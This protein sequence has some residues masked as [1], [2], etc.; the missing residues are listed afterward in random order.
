MSIAE[1]LTQIAKNQ[2]RVYEA[3]Y[4]RGRNSNA[5]SEGYDEGYDEGYMSCVNHMSMSLSLP[6]CVTP[7][8]AEELYNNTA[9]SEDPFVDGGVFFRRFKGINRIGSI[10]VSVATV[11]PQS[12]NIPQYINGKYIVFKMR[13]NYG[14]DYLKDFH[15]PLLVEN[16]THTNSQGGK[17]HYLGIDGTGFMPKDEWAV[18]VIQIP[19]ACPDYWKNVSNNEYHGIMSA[20]F[21]FYTKGGHECNHSNYYVDFAY[22]AVCKDMQEVNKLVGNDTCYIYD[23]SDKMWN[24]AEKKQ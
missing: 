14:G 16:D 13:T 22:S 17:G 3:G 15:C 23:A 8:D 2:Q 12:N 7:L 20:G 4:V 6:F 24:K 11:A 10:G 19:G 5:Y 21:A 9:T 18:Y 1:K